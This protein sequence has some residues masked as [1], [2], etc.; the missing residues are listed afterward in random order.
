[1]G[2]K[3]YT[4]PI[5]RTCG[6]CEWL[7]VPYP[8]QL[9][10]KRESVEELFEGLIE[11]LPA[12]QEE[13]RL[14]IHGMDEPL[15]Y[16]HKAATPFA[17]G[18]KG[19]IRSGFYARGTHRI[20]HCEECLVEAPKAREALNAVAAAARE[21]KIP[22]YN[23]D[24]GRG[25]LRHAIVR[26]GYNSSECLLTL[27]T[28][29]KSI[30]R[31]KE[32]VA[33]IRKRA[34][35]V[36]SIA[37]NVNQRQTNAILGFETHTLY[38]TGRMIDSLLDTEFEIGPTSFYQTNPEQ[39]EVLYSLAIEG[40]A[41]KSGMRVMDAYCGIGT[42]GLCAAQ[43]VEGLE[44][45]GVEQVEGAVKDARRNAKRNNLDERAQFTC[46]DATAFMRDTQRAGKHFDV[47][48]MDPPRAGSTPQ[49]LNGVLNLAPERVVYISCN[50]VTQR[51]D[52][53]TLLAGNYQLT[54]FDIVDM[55]PHTKHAE[56][57]AVLTHK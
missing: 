21:L 31:E 43:Q 11:D 55:F 37:Q 46:A 36:T 49:F 13:G 18:K 39:T 16:R 41:L 12:W 47:V 32:F 8:I 48:L 34:S 51:R 45:I 53:E 23:E 25:L 33:A 19:A 10:R 14:P 52:M 28:N 17:P 56:T 30:A 1:M 38:R 29:G 5:A 24:T 15:H 40:A 35:F 7:S 9:R 22:A 50:P 27:V 54:S 20:V 57:V 6:G 26:V 2:F 42:I 44:V 4:C 3:T